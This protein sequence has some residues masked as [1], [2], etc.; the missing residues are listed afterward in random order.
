MCRMKCLW[1]LNLSPASCRVNQ[2]RYD[3][4]THSKAFENLCGHTRYF[5]C[6]SSKR[7]PSGSIAHPNRPF[8]SSEI[9]L[10]TCTPSP[11]LLEQAVEIIHSI[12][13]HEG[14]RAALEILSISG[15]GRPYRNPYG[16]RPILF[17]PFEH[18]R[19]AGLGPL[20]QHPSRL[21]AFFAPYASTGSP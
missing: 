6:Q 10:S 19:F 13:D 21:S 5:G 14:G 7:L 2:E 1:H 16:L 8:A 18:R 9:L 4:T 12:I 17:A 15:I 3:I 20:A 11:R